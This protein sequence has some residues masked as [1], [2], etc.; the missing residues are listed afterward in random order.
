VPT[1]RPAGPC[2]L[3]LAFVLAATGCSSAES[4]PDLHPLTGTVTREGRP[5]TEGGVIFL[6]DPPNGSGLVV[7]A[8]VNPDG[9]FAAETSRSS[10]KGAEIRAGAPSGRYKVVYHPPGNGAKTGLEV[11]LEPRVTVER[12]ANAATLTLPAV[13]PRGNGVP[14]DD[15][16]NAPNFD[17]NRKDDAPDDVTP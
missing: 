12:G 7:N 5:V 8:S 10:G 1:Y 4:F 9:T 3:L 17:P 16:P 13:M 2:R 15:D 11:E 6:P 14:R